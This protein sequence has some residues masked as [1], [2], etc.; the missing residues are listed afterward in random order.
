MR[1]FGERTAPH[2]G[3][4]QSRVFMPAFGWRTE[5]R[6]PPEESGELKVKNIGRFLPLFLLVGSVPLASAQG[7]FNVSVGFGSARD[8]ATGL[9]IDN[10]SSPDN[11]FGSCSLQEASDVYCEPTPRLGR[12]FMGFAGEGMLNKHFGIGG[13]WLFQPAKGD[14]GPLQYRQTFYDFNG[15][16]APVV[17][18]NFVL[19]LQ[20]GVGGA[21]TGFSY[22]QTACVGTAVCNSY[23]QTVGTTNHLQVHAG[24]GLQVFLTQHVFVR[25]QFDFRHVTGFTAQFGRDNVYDGMI[26]L[27]YNFGEP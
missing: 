27:G 4:G 9:G 17:N 2:G 19:Q 18:K 14:Y 13:E 5:G 21:H 12:L 8:S 15:I 11:P 10:A 7:V 23:S 3:G 22:V 20:G 24:V 25:P 16:Y 1:L 6:P 26:W